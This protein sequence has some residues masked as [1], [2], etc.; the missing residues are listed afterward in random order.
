MTLVFAEAL[1]LPHEQL[2]EEPVSLDS[3][4][5][6]SFAAAAQRLTKVASAPPAASATAPSPSASMPTG[7]GARDARAQPTA[8]AATGRPG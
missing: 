8:D 5:S 1:C 6:I 2:L 3:G 4:H 7:S